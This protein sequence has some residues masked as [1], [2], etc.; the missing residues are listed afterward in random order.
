MEI[1]KLLGVKWKPHEGIVYRYDRWER[2]KKLAWISPLSQGLSPTPIGK[3]WQSIGK[4]YVV[5]DK[6]RYFGSFKVSGEVC[7]LGIVKHKHVIEIYKTET[8]NVKF[9]KR[10]TGTS[11]IHPKFGKTVNIMRHYEYV[12]KVVDHSKLIKE[13]VPR[14][15]IARRRGTAIVDTGDGILV[16]AG[17][18]NLFILPG[19]GAEKGESREEATI[20]ELKEETGLKTISI[21]YLFSYDDP[22]ERKIRNFHKVFLVKATGKIRPDG[23][24]VKHIGF[25][26]PGSDINISNTTSFIINK[27][28]TEFR[29]YEA[30]L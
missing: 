16:V 19:G 18:H 24:E 30:Q 27:Y 20:R 26:K 15:Q 8:S 4:V 3:R 29:K 23:H 25:W 14:H 21:K 12:A 10:Y 1:L 5:V 9:S 22:E 13:T 17:R 28:L 2:G 6:I 11:R 7:T